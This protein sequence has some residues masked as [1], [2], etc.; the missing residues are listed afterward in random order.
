M[1]TILVLLLLLLNAC[2]EKEI[3]SIHIDLNKA[4]I[5]NKE[6]EKAD[7]ETEFRQVIEN[8]LS[9]GVSKSDIKIQVTANKDIPTVEMS[10]VEKAIRRTGIERDYF[11]TD[12]RGGVSASRHLIIAINRFLIRGKN[13]WFR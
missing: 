10:E 12:K 7:F 9:F 6:I 2:S 13:Q 1:K 5:E 3:I 8:K 4:R 11:C